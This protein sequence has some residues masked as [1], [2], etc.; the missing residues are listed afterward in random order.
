MVAIRKFWGQVPLSLYFPGCNFF[1]PSFLKSSPM[2]ILHD[3]SSLGYDIRDFEVVKN[4]IEAHKDHRFLIYTD[5]RAIEI[6]RNSLDIPSIKFEGYPNGN[7]SKEKL[8]Y[9]ASKYNLSE[10]R[11]IG[12]SDLYSEIPNNS[13]LKSGSLLPNPVPYLETAESL[14]N[15]YRDFLDNFAV[16]YKSYKVIY[17]IVSGVKPL[18]DVGETPDEQR[19]EGQRQ[20]YPFE[21]IAKVLKEIQETLAQEKLALIPISAQY[22]SPV[23][24]SRLINQVNQAYRLKFPIQ[25]LD[26]ID[27][28]NKPEEQAAMYQAIH[29]RAHDLDLPSVAFGNASAYQHL[30]IAAT[31]GFDVSAIAIDSYHKPP[32]K[33][34]RIYWKEL[35]AGALPG[36]KVFQQEADSPGNWDSVTQA[37]KEYLVKGINTYALQPQS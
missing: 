13:K 28:S 1:N 26:F 36:L 23:E 11:T 5:Q 15:S 18:S 34:G 21:E 24:L 30:I 16:Q 22:G 14:V 17:A 27:W 33:D 20:T 7:F 9:L 8:L 32:H 35:G 29:Q 25:V 3:S 6:F 4:F 37:F 31:G 12:F 10:S 2:F 19:L